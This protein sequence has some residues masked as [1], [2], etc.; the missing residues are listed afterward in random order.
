MPGNLNCGMCFRN[1]VGRGV[2]VAVNEIQGECERACHSASAAPDGRHRPLCSV[3][4]GRSGD[5]GK[6]SNP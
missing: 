1:D 4:A 6:Q 3:F 2:G 5:E